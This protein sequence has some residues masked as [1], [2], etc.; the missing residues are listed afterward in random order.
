MEQLF[1]NFDTAKDRFL[2]QS[3]LP[4][5][6][7]GCSVHLSGSFT[8]QIENEAQY[9]FMAASGDLETILTQGFCACLAAA[10]QRC[11]ASP[12]AQDAALAQ[13]LADEIRAHDGEN[14]KKY[15]GIVPAD[16][17]IRQV[18]PLEAPE[19][20]EPEEPEPSEP[21]TPEPPAPEL[22]EPPVIVPEK[23]SGPAEPVRYW[24]CRCGRRCTGKFCMD[25]GA[26]R[27][28]VC[29]CGQPN[30]GGFCTNCGKKRPG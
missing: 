22:P 17:E 28:W 4:C 16:L 21:A 29:A 27:D 20:P 25:C 7:T 14:W 9:R 10:L 11:G 3:G 5:P 13:T 15:Y 12:A 30:Q 2:S 6:D 1:W 19:P 18:T 8:C 26:K 24:L 23:P